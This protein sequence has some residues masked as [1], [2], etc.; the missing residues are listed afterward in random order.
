MAALMQPPG[1]ASDPTATYGIVGGII[2]GIVFI[3]A[4]MAMSAFLGGRLFGPLR[5]I[6]SIVLGTEALDPSYS[7]SAAMLTGA[8][9]HLLLSSLFG[10]IFTEGVKLAGRETVSSTLIV[11]GFVF[12]SALWL[13]NFRVIAPAL[14]PQF[15]QVNQFWNGFIAHSLFYGVILGWY[16]TWVRGRAFAAR[17]PAA[18]RKRRYG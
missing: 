16:E 3:A 14:F 7:F 15:T 6:S 1:R 5:M 10:V 18:E 17:E 13:V 12:G 11:Y 8:I 9:L 2:A 4:E